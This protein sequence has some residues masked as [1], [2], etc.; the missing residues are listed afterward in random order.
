VNSDSLTSSFARPSYEE[1]TRPSRACVLARV[2]LQFLLDLRS[3]QALAI[4]QSFQN[5]TKH[6]LSFI[7]SAITNEAVVH[8]LA[9]G[10]AVDLRF[11]I[12]VVKLGEINHLISAIAGDI[13]I[14]LEHD[15]VW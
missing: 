15:F 3:L 8:V 1:P 2:G 12:V 5:G 9:V 13:S 10:S 7:F 14:D 6:Q 4:V 11:T